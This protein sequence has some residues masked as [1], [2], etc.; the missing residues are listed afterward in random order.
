[1]TTMEKTKEAEAVNEALVQLRQLYKDFNSVSASVSA[2]SA[3][4]RSFETGIV[5]LLNFE[6]A[7]ERRKKAAEINLASVEQQAKTRLMNIEQNNRTIIDRL[8]QKEME[9]ERKMAEAVAKLADADR[10]VNDAEML[11]VHYEELLAKATASLP[12]KAKK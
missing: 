12:A 11:K 6:D 3:K 4:M 8:S 7:A 10:R 1:M 9:A 2:L 5:Q